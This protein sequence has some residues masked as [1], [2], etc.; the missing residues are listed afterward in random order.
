MKFSTLGRLARDPFIA[1]G[2]NSTMI[3]LVIAEENGYQNGQSTAAFPTV[4]WFVHSKKIVDA[5][6]KAMQKGHLVYA[7]GVA[8]Q[9]SYVDKNGEKHYDT[10]LIVS[11]IQ[12]NLGK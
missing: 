10:D 6:K 2:E 11:D 3:S 8:S 5:A 4:K 7:T 12:W 9:N 1:E